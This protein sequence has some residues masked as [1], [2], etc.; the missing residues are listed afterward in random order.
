MELS[1]T[2]STA[3][4]AAHEQMDVDDAVDDAGKGTGADQ[5]GAGRESCEDEEYSVPSVSFELDSAF[6]AAVQARAARRII[7][8]QDEL[9][10]AGRPNPAYSSGTKTP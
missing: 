10:R 1:S 5:R 4:T 2:A 6:E 7:D 3:S 8:A 9:L